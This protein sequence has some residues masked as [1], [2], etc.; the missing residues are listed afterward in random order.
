MAKNNSKAIISGNL[1]FDREDY[2][3]RSLLFKLQKTSEEKIVDAIIEK[4]T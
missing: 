2:L 3:N 1:D 4:Y